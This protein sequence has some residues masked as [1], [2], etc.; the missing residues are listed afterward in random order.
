MKY[1]NVSLAAFMELRNWKKGN[2]YSNHRVRKFV[3]RW[4]TERL[5]TGYSCRVLIGILIFNLQRLLFSTFHKKAVS[6]RVSHEIRWLM[7]TRVINNFLKLHEEI[8]KEISF[9]CSVCITIWYKTDKKKNISSL[10]YLLT[11]MPVYFT[12][13]SC[14]N[15]HSKW[16]FSS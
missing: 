2:E 15:T 7:V 6:L 10:W 4:I 16:A 11:L 13:R 5:I 1:L 9:K 14:F 8:W 12:N 3:F